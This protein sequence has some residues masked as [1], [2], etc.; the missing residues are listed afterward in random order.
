HPLDVALERLELLAQLVLALA[1]LER[2]LTVHAAAQAAVDAIVE[3]APHPLP[4]V[5]LQLALPPV[6]LGRAIREIRERLVRG[7]LPPRRHLLERRLQ[8]PAR[9]LDRP[10]RL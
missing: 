3:E 1:E 9:L 6:E 8:L 7:L 2:L 10:L 4:Q 5:G